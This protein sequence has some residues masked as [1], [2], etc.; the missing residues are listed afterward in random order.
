AKRGIEIVE[1][2]DHPTLA[3]N[4]FTQL[5][6]IYFQ[7]GRDAESE[8]IYRRA[9]E[10]AEESGSRRAIA[11]AL[12]GYACALGMSD[13][14]AAQPLF[15]RAVGL[16]RSEGLAGWLAHAYYNRALIDYRHGEIQTALGN[17][18]RAFRT[19]VE[20]GT[21]LGQTPLTLAGNLLAAAG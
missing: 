12:T 7:A 20:S 10:I 14:S 13:Y 21:A 3:A 1:G 2:M 17:L 5:G 18:I 16:R 8:P 4:A 9:L 19:F 11:D 15:D 6:W